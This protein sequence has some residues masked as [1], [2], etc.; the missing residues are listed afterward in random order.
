MTVLGRAA[1][2]GAV[3]AAGP[4]FFPVSARKLLVMSLLTLSLYEFYWFYRNW[5]IEKQSEHPQI[6]PRCQRAS[7]SAVPRTAVP[8]KAKRAAT[9]ARSR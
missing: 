7:I 9:K 2:P 1:G 4:P 3:A 5:Q 8:A 6:M